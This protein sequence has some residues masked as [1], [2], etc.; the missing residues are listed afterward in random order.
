M[1]RGHTYYTNFRLNDSTSFVRLSLSE[2]RRIT[3]SNPEQS[4]TAN[5]KTLCVYSNSIYTLTFV[6]ESQHCPYSK[7]FDI[8]DSK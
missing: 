5:G 4:S 3:M 2:L 8:V 6:T 7:S 1:I